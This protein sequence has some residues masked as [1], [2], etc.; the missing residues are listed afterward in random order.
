MKMTSTSNVKLSALM[1]LMWCGCF[2]I[3]GFA[4]GVHFPLRGKRESAPQISGSPSHHP[5]LL[6]SAL[7]FVE[8]CRGLENDS[9]LKTKSSIKGKYFV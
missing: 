5:H 4:V 2:G 7:S 9:V 3:A 8:I 6:L 1:E